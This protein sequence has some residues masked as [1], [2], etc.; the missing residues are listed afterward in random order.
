MIVIL[1]EVKNLEFCEKQILS[2]AQN[3][4]LEI[5][6]TLDFALANHC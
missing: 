1:N 4:K 6:N 5:I 2:S 3:D